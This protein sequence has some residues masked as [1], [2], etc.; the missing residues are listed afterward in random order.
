[1]ITPKYRGDPTAEGVAGPEG[2]RG[3]PFRSR[4]GSIPLTTK[5]EFSELVCEYDVEVAVFKTG[6][7]ESL[8]RYRAYRDRC[9]NGRV[10]PL[11]HKMI[12]DP[13]GGGWLIFCEWAVPYETTPGPRRGG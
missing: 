12:E 7:P 3:Y 11:M 6:D 4:D 1:M 13:T 8:D 5:K 2:P 10:K 9:V